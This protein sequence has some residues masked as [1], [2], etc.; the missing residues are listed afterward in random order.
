MLASIMSRDRARSRAVNETAKAVLDAEERKLQREIKREEEKKKQRELGEGD[1]AADKGAAN[2][3]NYYDIA[4]GVK[5]GGGGG[6]KATTTKD[7][8]KKKRDKQKG[9]DGGAKN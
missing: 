4:E 7:M 1:S 6:K 2:K 9:D 3:T 5:D 8:I